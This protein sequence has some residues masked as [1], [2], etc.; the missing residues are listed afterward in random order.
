MRQPA[1]LV[2]VIFT[3]TDKDDIDIVHGDIYLSPEFWETGL[4]MEKKKVKRVD[5]VVKN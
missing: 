5:T 2:W 4:N 1:W 3:M